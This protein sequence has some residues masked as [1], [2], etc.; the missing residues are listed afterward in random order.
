MQASVLFLV[1]AKLVLLQPSQDENGISKY[2]MRIIA[3]SVEYFT[4]TCDQHFSG[5]RTTPQIPSP[6]TEVND[7]LTETSLQ[8]S[9]WYF[10]GENVQC[11]PDVQDLIRG[12]SNDSTEDLPLPISVL[13]DFYPTS[14]DIKKGLIIGL[15]QDLVQRRDAA[16]AFC[17]LSVKVQ[18]SQIC[19][20]CD[21]DWD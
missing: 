4:F 14:I 2:D 17:R 6:S 3:N 12:T 9:L 21:A 18:K 8:E 20:L 19:C 16:F 1:D 10:N 5:S 7:G 15:D 13:V 11:W